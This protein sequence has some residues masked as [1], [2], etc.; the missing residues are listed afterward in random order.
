MKRF[1]S[2]QFFNVPIVLVIALVY[3]NRV[4]E[5]VTIEKEFNP[6]LGQDFFKK[7]TLFLF[8]PERGYQVTFSGTSSRLYKTPGSDPIEESDSLYL[9]LTTNEGLIP[10]FNGAASGKVSFQ[11]EDILNW[12]L[13][14]QE[15]KIAVDPL[16]IILKGYMDSAKFE[17]IIQYDSAQYLSVSDSNTIIESFNDIINDWKFYSIYGDTIKQLIFD[18]A[19]LLKLQNEAK[20][21]VDRN[22]FLDTGGTVQGSL[23]MIDQEKLKWFN[24]IV[25]VNYAGHQTQTRKILMK[26]PTS[27]RVFSILFQR[28]NS[29][30]RIDE[31]RTE[32]YFS[33]N[34]TIM[35]QIAS[36]E[37]D[38]LLLYEKFT[39]VHD[40]SL[41]TRSP[42]IVTP[43]ISPL[44]IPFVSVSEFRKVLLPGDAFFTLLRYSE[45]GDTLYYNFKLYYVLS[46]TII[47]EE[48]PV[49][50]TGTITSKINFIKLPWSIEHWDQGYLQK[51]ETDI[52]VRK[53]THLGEITQFTE[54]RELYVEYD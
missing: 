29:R 13:L 48:K 23:S 24:W 17:S 27:E 38:T 11:K 47:R 14:I 15:M 54:K 37:N 22:I 26:Y 16:G 4:P 30:E 39:K 51:W 45:A 2:R 40:Y 18:D 43:L 21:M 6:Q 10:T 3:C 32:R 28:G 44:D 50:I 49:D 35:R 41:T 12:H 33:Y 52:H 46:G 5:M 36:K 1:K 31:T 9:R 8:N 42:F 19:L 20:Y 53:K 7:D 34:N 25:V